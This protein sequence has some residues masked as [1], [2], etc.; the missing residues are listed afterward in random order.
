VDGK[1]LNIKNKPRL[2]VH[3]FPARLSLKITKDREKHKQK[4]R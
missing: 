1:P 3:L 4:K 2:P